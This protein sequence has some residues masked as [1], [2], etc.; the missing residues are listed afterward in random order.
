VI[1]SRFAGPTD[2]RMGLL[3]SIGREAFT[4]VARLAGL[5]ITDPTSGFQALNRA[6][7]ELYARDFYPSDYPDVDVLVTAHRH[8]LRIEERPVAMSQGER[9]SSLHGGLRG[10]YYVYKMLL[11]SWAASSR[12]PDRMR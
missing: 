1:A 6:V 9:R 2:Y 5:H 11:S 10:F 3:R 12:A 7:L 4:V 8:G